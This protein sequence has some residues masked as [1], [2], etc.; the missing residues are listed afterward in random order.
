MK[1]LVCAQI[2]VGKYGARRRE[3]M[4]KSGNFELVAVCDRSSEALA[5]AA[6]EE[7]A[8][9]YEGYS[10]MLE[11]PGLEAVVISTGADSHA[12]LVLEAFRKRLHVYVEKPLCASLDELRKLRNAAR[13]SGVLTGIGHNFCPLVPVVQLAKDYIA[14][15]KLGTIASFEDNSSHSGSWSIKPGD[16]RGLPGCNPGGMIFQCG[17]HELH[18]LNYLFGRA[19]A[20][21]AMFRYD[22]NPATQTADVANVLLR[23]GDLLGTL[24]CYHVTPY[25]HELRVFGT[26]ANLHCDTFMNTASI[27]HRRY[28]GGIE[29]REAVAVPTLGDRDIAGLNSWFNGIRTGTAV[30][31]SIDDGVKA[32]LPVFAAE[33]AATEKR[34]IKISE[35][36]A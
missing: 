25:V 19:T 4:R 20:V 29:E 28:D 11:H 10:A 9:P 34:E 21:Q 7:N 6:R 31:P 26:L 12:A 15:G 33:R 5:A 2:G 14:S 3:C 22:V 24:N 16:W 17:V 36:E 30:Y 1:R 35:M 13:E 27:Q 32:L 8:K 23:Y 18:T